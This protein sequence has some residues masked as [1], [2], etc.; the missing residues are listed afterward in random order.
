M[1]DC[2]V[3]FAVVVLVSFAVLAPADIL[4]VAW[5]VV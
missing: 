5:A 3:P 2:V 1:F 4:V